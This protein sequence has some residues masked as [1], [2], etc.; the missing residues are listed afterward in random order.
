MASAILAVCWPEDFPVYDYR[1][2]DQILDS[3]K[4]SQ[5]WKFERIWEAY[6]KY[7]AKVFEL[8]PEES[9][10]RNKDRF[11]YGKSNALQLEEDIERLFKKVDK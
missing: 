10:L 2:R 8:V 5:S 6:E 1:V 9:S 3:P 7:K 11:L 4:V